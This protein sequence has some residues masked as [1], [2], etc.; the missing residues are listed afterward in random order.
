MIAQC[1]S[2]WVCASALGAGIGTLVS[3]TIGAV[4][5]A[6]SNYVVY[7]ISHPTYTFEC[8]GSCFGMR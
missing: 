4:W 1:V 3:G 6:A 5:T 7:A 8:F 2:S